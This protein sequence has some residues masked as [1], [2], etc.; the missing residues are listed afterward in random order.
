MSSPPWTIV[1]RREIVS[2]V[3]DKAFIIGTVLML[4]M[5]SGFVLFQVLWGERTQTHTIAVLPAD[6]VMADTVARG[7]PTQDSKVRIDLRAVDSPRAAEQAVME[8]KASAWLH[9]RD[10]TWVL[11]GK[12]DVDSGLERAVSVVV[13]RSVIEDNARAAG[14]DVAAIEQGATMATDLLVGDAEQQDFARFMGFALAILF[15]M[16]S[17]GFG[18]TIAG[19]VVEEKASRIVEII[20]TKIPIRQLLVGKVLG[21]TIL[22]VAQTAIFVGVGLLGLSFTSY[23]SLLPA[24]S[25]GVGWFLVYFLIGF[26]LIACLFAV[27][28][29]LASR[30]EDLQ[31]TGMPMTM[32][33]MVVFFASFL[34]TGT[35]LTVLSHIPPFSAVLMP[36][37]VLQ[38]TAAW[39]EPWVALVV[40]L[41]AAGVVIL[42]AERL[43]RRALL[44][45]QGRL[46]IRQA[47]TVA[48]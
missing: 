2:K 26:L 29:A 42:V 19:S 39:W 48:E 32:L 44:Q 4:A 37:R 17:L 7:V 18:F 30:S 38:G 28:G 47:W 11:T 21:N 25:S 34:A 31:Q 5:I 13:R 1:T 24:V 22:A 43:Y 40:L 9:H 10:G 16:A 12:K 14:T 45:T 20:A 15:Y 41:A 46:S 33:L 8:G 35:A 3:T 27:V 23:K 6:T 36:I